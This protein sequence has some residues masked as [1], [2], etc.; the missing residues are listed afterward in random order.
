MTAPV[1][2]V[3]TLRRLSELDTDGHPVL[4]VYLNLGTPTA[5]AQILATRR[6]TIEVLMSGVVRQVGKANADRV[7]EQLRSRSMSGLAHGTRSLALFSSIAGPTCELVPLPCEVETMTVL[8]TIPWLEPLAGMF[9][10]GDWGVA[11]LG[12]RTAR[13]LRGNPRVLVEFA[14]VPDRRHYTPPPGVCTQHYVQRLTEEHIA[15]LARRVA[16]LLMRAHRRRAF[17]H[18]VVAAPREAWPVIEDAL[19]SDLHGRLTGLVALDLEHA[20]TPE[21]THALAAVVTQAQCGEREC[22]RCSTI[23]APAFSGTQI[24]AEET[25]TRYLQRLGWPRHSSCT[26]GQPVAPL[27][28]RAGRGSPK[29]EVVCL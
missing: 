2:G 5:G 14:A 4:S 20:S 24:T 18:L 28:S 19:H 15:E 10:T 12:S 21:I 27:L 11:V 7:H 1:V 29:M 26:P 9:A 22:R 17:E 6:A 25:T 3:G 23:T 16:A 8:D 13:L